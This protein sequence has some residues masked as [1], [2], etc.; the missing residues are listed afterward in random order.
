MI[1]ILLPFIFIGVTSCQDTNSHS[2]DDRIYG[3]PS[4]NSG[5]GEVRPSYSRARQVLEAYC[6][7]CHYHASWANFQAEKTWISSGLVVSRDPFGSKL[8][9]RL[10]GCE[11]ASQGG[12]PPRSSGK[13]PLKNEECQYIED[14]IRSME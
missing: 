2:A 4:E 7:N 5:A 6:I 9:Y 3:A 1:K 12:M 8:Y 13:R 11:N 14:W 10:E